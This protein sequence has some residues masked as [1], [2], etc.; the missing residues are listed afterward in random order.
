MAE[1]F[2]KRTIIQG[3]G[4][5]GGVITRKDI[6][7]YDFQQDENIL[8]ASYTLAEAQALTTLPNLPAHNRLVGVG[9][10]K[11]LIDINNSTFGYDVYAIYDTDGPKSY[12]YIR[13]P[14][15]G[16]TQFTIGVTKPSGM[17][18]VHWGDGTS[19]TITAS[20]TQSFVHAYGAYAN[21]SDYEVTIES[22]TPYTINS[23]T[24]NMLRKAYFSSIVNG[25]STS[26]V[27]GSKSLEHILYTDYSI[28]P[29][30]QDCSALKNTI[31]FNSPSGQLSHSANYSL[32]HA[33]INAEQLNWGAFQNCFALKYVNAGSNL[34]T[35]D[36]CFQNCWSVLEYDFTGYDT[37]PTLTSTDCF[38]GINSICKIRVKASA[39][40]SFKKATNWSVY[41]NYMV[42]V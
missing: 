25:F 2:L 34:T 20:G 38:S 10:S 26:V 15:V 8:V 3:K 41:A 11:D 18:I 19:T 23:I 37:P 4:T 33:F 42:G 6:N 9:W 7:F 36:P 24:N 12:L 39:L 28:E 35:L 13:T 5:G 31:M 40:Y 21:D 29:S 16:S 30:F 32:Q 27:L 22:H 1:C 17:M 14:V